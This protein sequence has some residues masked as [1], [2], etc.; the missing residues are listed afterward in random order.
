VR[1]ISLII[2]LYFISE[3][4][5]AQQ[6]IVKNLQTNEILEN[7]AVYN[8]RKDKSV[9]TDESGI[10]SVHS[11]EESDTLFFQ[12]PA[13]ETFSAPFSEI[14]AKGTILLVRKN[15]LIPEFVITASKHRES[16]TEVPYLVDVISTKKLELSTSQ[17]SA[18]VLT[19]SGNVFVQKSQVG[20]GSPILRGFEANRVLLVVDGV[21]MNNAIYRSGHLQNSLTIDNAVLERVEVI[22][23]PSSV[24]YG[25][26][27]LGGV[28]HYITKTP[29]FADSTASLKV[30]GSSYIQGASASTGIKSHIDLNFGFKKLAL[31]SSVT[32]GAFGDMRMGYRRN[33]FFE[34]WG[35]QPDYVQRINGVDSLVANTNPNYIRPAGYNQIDLLQKIIYKPNSMV[36]FQA[37][38]QYS[39][40]TDINRQDQ[41][42]NRLE[43]GAP[44]FSEWYY[45]PQERLLTMLK[46]TVNKP[47][48]F[49]TT[50]EATLAYQDIEESRYT[51][52]FRIDT[53]YQQIE[54]VKI[55]SGNFDFYKQISNKQTVSYGIEL[56]FNRVSS[57]A[58]KEN[59]VSG[60]QLP[61]ITR[62]PDEG[63]STMS[64]GAYVAYKTRVHPKLLTSIGLRYQYYI[65]NA[66][67]GEYYQELPEVFQNI[68]LE[69]QA[70]TSTLSLIVNQ[71]RS[72][73]WNVIFST[74]F[75][76]PNLDDLSK[77]RL[78]SGKLTL[79]NSELDPEY[80]YN[81][82]FGLSKTFDG[83]IQING[84]YF[85][86]YLTDA[87]TRAAYT[88]EDGSDSI[89]FQGSYRTTYQN[90]NSS[91]ALLHGFSLNLV[92]DLN[93]NVSFR[94][95][96]NYTYGRN[97]TD[98]TPMAHIPPIFG[99]TDFSYELKR[100]IADI[101]IVYSGWKH[102]RDIVETGE[103]KEEEAT[104]YGFPGWYTINLT[105]GF[106]FNE[107]VVFQ[108]SIENMT[109]NFYMPFA[110]G[111]PAPGINFV[112]A[113][114]VKF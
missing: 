97:L 90:V 86:S 93:S 106:N 110:S 26:D 44:E 32:Y 69:N 109:D 65:L 104:I 89:Y 99:R 35:K 76:S 21:R 49:F 61:D 95:T 58:Q 66:K 19:A 25:S 11:F 38:I 10:A 14:I 74:G 29:Q 41:L 100:F 51:R 13:Y 16:R 71:T 107:Y 101:Y 81:A 15:I 60:L 78:T 39:N 12:H 91:E 111:V 43:D 54:G 68:N 36:D 113:L 2:L 62:Y 84:N 80:S 98:N 59:I 52:E 24:I 82:E 72:F 70:I 102:M 64:S 103:D 5:N 83:Y 3:T 27:A 45:G 114:R 20:G 30:G 22:F 42:N 108:F 55:G 79:P 17:N 77:I 6:I 9:I 46:S 23:G 47:N 18:D 34:D 88:F 57:V 56:N 96:L 75:R 7:V 92:S 50:F 94:S 87:I 67:Y 8:Q 37:N 33:P 40:S 112:S 105:T 53:L 31:L 28:I 73:N 63:T 1:Y 85:I 4:V 48:D